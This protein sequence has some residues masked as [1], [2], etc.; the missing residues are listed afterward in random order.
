MQGEYG[1]AQTP[2]EEA[3][4]HFR[5]VNEPAG[6]ASVLNNLG[7][8]VAAGWDTDQNYA[9]A[10]SFYAEAI[11]VARSTDNLLELTGG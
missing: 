8:L 10:R 3:L 9:A 1:E 2:L 6:I 7:N 5:Q 4:A 11:G